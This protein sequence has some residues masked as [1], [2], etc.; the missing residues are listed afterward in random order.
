M[1]KYAGYVWLLT[2]SITFHSLDEN[3]VTTLF[4]DEKKGNLG[5]KRGRVMSGDEFECTGYARE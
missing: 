4:V 1:Q 3:F 2:Y 5:L